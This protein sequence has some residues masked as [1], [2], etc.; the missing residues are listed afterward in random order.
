MFSPRGGMQF[1]CEQKK[2][3]A[4]GQEAAS[5]FKHL[6]ENELLKNTIDVLS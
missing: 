5:E 4:L 2:K 6:L 1:H 3:L